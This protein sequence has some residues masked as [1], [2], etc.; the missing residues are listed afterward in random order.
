VSVLCLGHVAAFYSKP[1]LELEGW[2]QRGD[3]DRM[4]FTDRWP[5]A[6]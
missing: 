4:I 1:M 2:E 5:A 6:V 3:L